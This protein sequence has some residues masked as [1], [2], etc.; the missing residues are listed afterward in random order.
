M[1]AK[2]PELDRI[3][4]ELQAAATA[5]T[6]TVNALRELLSVSVEHDD[7]AETVNTPKV[8]LEEVRAVLAEISRSGKM[9]Q[10]RELIKKYGAEK[11]TEVD[12]GA[13]AA[14]LAE[15]EAL[16]NG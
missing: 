15:A 3:L 7:P 1:M 9:V 11:L 5:I 13:F 2:M 4:A 10:V 6:V 16:Q 14:L 8:S 12:P